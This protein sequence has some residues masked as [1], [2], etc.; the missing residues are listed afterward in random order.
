GRLYR[1]GDRVRWLG[2]GT[3]EFLGRSDGQVK[4]RGFRI[5]PGEIEAALGTHQLAREVA[6]VLREDAPGDKRVVAYVACD[7]PEA[8]SQTDWRG[9]LRQRLPEYMIPSAFVCLRQLPLTPNGKLD[10][11][12]LPAPEFQRDGAAHARLAPRTPVEAALLDIWRDLLHVARPG[13]DD[14]F[15]DL[16]GHSLMATQVLSRVRDLFGVEMPLRV[17]FEEP[18]PAGLA[19]HVESLLAGGVRPAAPP[20]EP[21]ARDAAL[22]LSFA[23]QRLWI[24]DQ[25]EPGNPRYNLTHALRLRGSLDAAALERSIEEIVRRHETLRTTFAVVGRTPAQVIHP[26]A[27]VKPDFVDLGHLP[28][29]ERESEARRLADAQALQRFDLA[30]GPLL[31]VGLLRLGAAEHVFV[32]TIHHIISDGWSIGVWVNELTAL[33]NSYSRGLPASLPTLPIQYADFAKWQH[34]LVE[35]GALSEQL[36]YWKRQLAD[37]PPPLELPFDR[38]RPARPTFGGATLDF[39]LPAATYN[40]LQELSRR[41]GVTLYMAL[42]AGFKALLHRYTGR[43]DVTVG[44]AIANRNQPGVE[45]LIGFFVNMLVMRTDLSGDPTFRGLLAR[46]RETALGA[47]AHQDV[48]FDTLVSALRVERQGAVN[49]LFQT[50]FILQNAPLEALELTGLTLT[51]FEVTN[52]LAHLDLIF[53]LQETDGRLAGIIQYSTELFDEETVARLLSGYREILE[54]VAADPEKRLSELGVS[55][56]AADDDF[57]LRDLPEVRLNREQLASLLQ[58]FDEP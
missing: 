29:A 18:T 8:A 2:D 52:P 45:G 30:A 48:P 16:G 41:E 4:V 32:L 5:E 49:P 28:A 34:E 33:Y 57:T 26:D 15:F 21:T 9:F 20:L 11:R 31:R 39:E 42:L 36:A 37:A 23:Q 55:A 54:V 35:G 7:D 50:L 38:E 46:V 12:A 25:L 22:P 3:I 43:E 10:R 51:N 53:S 6:V 40:A 56:A 58:D 27:T 13:L 19:A 1:T 44:A 17:I 24:M 47:Y 14:N